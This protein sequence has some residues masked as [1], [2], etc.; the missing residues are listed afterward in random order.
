MLG[1]LR[2]LAVRLAVQDRV[3]F[4]GWLDEDGC[5]DY[6]AAADVAI[7]T[8]L[9]P[10]V[11]PVKGMEYMAFGVP[12]VAFGLEETVAMAKDAA[13]YVPR[14]NPTALAGAINDLLDDPARRAAMA[15]AGRRRVEED[16]AWDHQSETYLRVFA[17]LLGQPWTAADGEGT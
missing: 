17:R 5:F 12:F 10:E 2:R 4:T 3:T 1:E 16:L 11:S 7:D 6:L 9:Q 8:N 13:V 14:G 15:R